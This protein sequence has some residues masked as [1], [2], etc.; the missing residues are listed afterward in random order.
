MPEPLT[1][2]PAALLAHA[3]APRNTSPL[4][5]PTHTAQVDNPLCGDRVRLVLSLS[6]ARI[7]ELSHQTRGCALCIASASVM[8]E[9][10][11]GASPAEAAEA[12]AV[13]LHALEVSPT[14]LAR[15]VLGMF[16]GISAAPARVGCVALPWQALAVALGDLA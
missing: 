16:A 8:T 7:V 6:D 12:R 14:S 1:L 9:R 5:A 3:R 4:L 2:Y 15:E 10:L 11:A 13:F